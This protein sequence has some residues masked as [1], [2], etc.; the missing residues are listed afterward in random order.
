MIRYVTVEGMFWDVERR[1]YT[2]ERLTYRI[3]WSDVLEHAVYF[4]VARLVLA[5][6]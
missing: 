6:A 3:E 4:L 1:E 2:R 5:E